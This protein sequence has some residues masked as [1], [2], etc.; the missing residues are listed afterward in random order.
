MILIIDPDGTGWCVYGE[1]LNL[2][3]LGKLTVTR[4]SR[5]E[6]DASGRWSADLSQMDGPVLGP[7]DRRSEALAAESQ[8][9]EQHWLLGHPV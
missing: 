1:A 7:F 5:V 6:P 2:A 4:A 3:E 8:W 9:L